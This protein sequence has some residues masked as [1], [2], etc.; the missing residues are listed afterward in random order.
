MLKCR[1]KFNIMKKIIERN[2]TNIALK[3]LEA[4]TQSVTLYKL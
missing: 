3:G 4:K 1:R 2:K